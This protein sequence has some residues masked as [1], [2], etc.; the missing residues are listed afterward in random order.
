MK[1]LITFKPSNLNVKIIQTQIYCDSNTDKLH[2]T[3]L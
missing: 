2:T 1:K 3:T